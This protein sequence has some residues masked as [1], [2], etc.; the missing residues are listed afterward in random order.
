MACYCCING[1]DC[2]V[3]N[4]KVDSYWHIMSEVDAT[5]RYVYIQLTDGKFEFS[6][7]HFSSCKN[8]TFDTSNWYLDNE[9]YRYNMAG[10]FS[11]CTY[12]KSIDLSRFDFSKATSF[13]GMFKNCTSLES[14]IEINAPTLKWENVSLSEMFCKCSALSTIKLNFNPKQN[15]IGSMY[16]TFGICKK[17]KNLTLNLGE[18]HPTS[19]VGTFSQC[20]VLGPWLDLRD[21]YGERCTGFSSMFRNCYKL[22]L[23]NLY[24]I[25]DVSNASGFT[26][27]F[28]GDSKLSTVIIAPNTRWRVPHAIDTIDADMFKNCTSLPGYPLY[29]ATVL[30]YELDRANSL[31][32]GVIGY[33]RGGPYDPRV[34][35][36]VSAIYYKDNGRW[37][38]IDNIL[39][40]EDNSWIAQD[41]Y[42]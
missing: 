42:S 13:E 2:Y 30:N 34:P 7:A 31:Q 9:K 8:S 11:D 36:L 22:E 1:D 21:F 40:K 20:E 3:S 18:I 19:L 27:M 6:G 28:Y 14:P 16:Y 35:E 32:P 24:N 15:S 23:L 25:T 38:Q 4:T 41:L 12:L 29:A 10:M 17:L 39:L 5:N 26:D 37:V 33:F